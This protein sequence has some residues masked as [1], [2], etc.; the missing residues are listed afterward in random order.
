MLSCIMKI[1]SNGSLAL[2]C[3]LRDS[4]SISWYLL[5]CIIVS[6]LLAFHDFPLQYGF[7]MNVPFKWQKYFTCYFVHFLLRPLFTPCLS[8]TS[9]LVFSRNTK[10]EKLAKQAGIKYSRPNRPFS[11][12]ENLHKLIFIAYCDSGIDTF[13]HWYRSLY[14]V[15]SLC[16]LCLKKNHNIYGDIRMNESEPWTNILKKTNHYDYTEPL[17]YRW[18]NYDESPTPSVLYLYGVSTLV[19]SHPTLDIVQPQV[20]FSSSGVVSFWSHS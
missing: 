4:S 7:N 8:R 15:I 18:V 19:S 13:W 3:T 2:V 10:Y 20:M 6:L 5:I 12:R 17:P 14:N 11:N 9:V 16:D 1:D